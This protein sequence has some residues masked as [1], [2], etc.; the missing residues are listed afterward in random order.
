MP[1]P[2]RPAFT[3][4]A[5]ESDAPISSSASETTRHFGPTPW[6]SP[7]NQSTLVGGAGAD[8]VTS[9]SLGKS[10]LHRPLQPAARGT[11]IAG[12]CDET[13][14]RRRKTAP[15][16]FGPSIVSSQAAF[17]EQSPSQPTKTELAVGFA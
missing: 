15:T 16:D 9:V 7:P 11:L 2:V 14:K 17:P 3:D 6:Q 8:S 1:Y 5:C 4:L 10:L 13:T 12:P